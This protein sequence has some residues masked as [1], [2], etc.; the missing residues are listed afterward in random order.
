MRST[1]SERSVDMVASTCWSVPLTRRLSSWKI[2][3]WLG[4]AEAV[5]TGAASAATT[6]AAAS[7]ARR[8]AAHPYSS[9][10]SSLS[11]R[12]LG[13][14]RLALAQAAAGRALRP[15]LP[16]PPPPAPPAAAPPPLPRRRRAA[17]QQAVAPQD[18]LAALLSGAAQLSPATCGQRRGAGLFAHAARA[19]WR[20]GRGT[21]LRGP[22]RARR[23]G[24]PWRSSNSASCSQVCGS[25]GKSRTVRSRILRATPS[26][27]A[28][29]A[30][31]ASAKRGLASQRVGLARGAWPLSAALARSPFSMLVERRRRWPGWNARAARWRR[32]A[33][34]R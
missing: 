22:P 12:D 17:G 15:R 2:D 16:P 19:P 1:P 28:A 27:P 4:E 32:P 3:S 20:T 26:R 34:R 29:A 7:S 5:E 23:S 9:I 21:A 18:L 14:C 30:T 8:A 25:P 33:A 24:S 11:G 6:A 10:G 31:E 13:P